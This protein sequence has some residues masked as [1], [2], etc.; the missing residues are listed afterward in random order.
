MPFKMFIFVRKS[1]LLKTLFFLLFIFSSIQAEKIVQ[2]ITNFPIPVENY[3]RALQERGYDGKVVIVDLKDYD[4]VLLKKKRRWLDKLGLNHFNRV[5][6]PKNVDKIVFFNLNSKIARKYDLSRLP[7]E[8]LVL[9]MW[10]PKTVLRRMYL[11][12]VQDWFSK[13]YTWDDSLVDGKR[14][15][16]FYYPVLKAM[17]RDIPS[18]EQKK[19]CTLVATDLQSKYEN[20]LYS[21]RKKAIRFFEQIGE[22]GFEFFGRRWNPAEY[23]SYRGSVTDKIETIK[24]YRFSICYEN[25]HRVPGYITEKIFDC[26]AAG[27]IPIYW[28][29]SNIEKY[30]PTDCFIDRRAFSTMEELYM[31]LKGMDQDT[32]EGYLERIRAFLRSEVAQRFT[33]DQLEEAFYQAIIH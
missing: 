6:L 13:I 10:E 2:C 30:I 8:K 24:Q 5:D 31:F 22:E 32:Y 18:F 33:Q 14:Y 4:D 28:G 17:H 26:F 7:K 3:T 9:F 25:T 15:F 27:T 16:K 20:E 19:F 12:R 21:E 23:S 1:L 11:P 29:A